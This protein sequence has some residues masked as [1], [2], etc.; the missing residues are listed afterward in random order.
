MT[1][2]DAET[3]TDR[4]DLFADAIEAHRER[5]SPFITIEPEPTPA[6]MAAA[7]DEDLPEDAPEQTVPWIQLADDTVNLDCTDAELERVKTLLEEYPDFRID[8]LTSPADAHGTNVRITARADPE[9]LGAF[10]DR[11][12]REVYGREEDYRAWVVEI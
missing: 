2:F 4:R 1:R 8:D 3:L 9:R 11:I 7:D 6:E 12:F 10:F 5:R